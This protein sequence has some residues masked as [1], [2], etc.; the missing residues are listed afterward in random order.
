MFVSLV[1]A[2]AYA[3]QCAHEAVT[4]RPTIGLV[5]GGGGA[6]GA[7]HIGV[8][9]VLEA[10]HIP[11]DYVAGT[12]MGSLVGGPYAAGMNADQL[13]ATVS[14]INFGKLFK[15][16]TDRKDEPFRRKRDDDL[17]LY[18]PKLGIGANSQL[19]P[20]GALHG[21]KILFLFET[22]NSQRVQTK[23]FDALPIPYRAVATDVVTGKPAVL[24]DGDLA[25]AMRSSMS[26]PG[27]FD[28]V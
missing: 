9:R 15:D 12:S 13:Q 28:P 17:A 14:N 18:G 5:L 16:S 19:L 2:T 20:A 23:N 25:V 7:A 11:V 3:N 24:G 21:Q 10:L 4:D 8:I 26:V 22:L 27:V 6:R 1:S